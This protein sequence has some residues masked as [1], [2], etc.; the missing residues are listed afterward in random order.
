M[1][2]EYSRTETSPVDT[3][4]Q[5]RVVLSQ[6]EVL[7]ALE[8]HNVFTQNFSQPLILQVPKGDVWVHTQILLD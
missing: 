8:L 5:L 1:S 2:L 3:A 6:A 4:V 7:W